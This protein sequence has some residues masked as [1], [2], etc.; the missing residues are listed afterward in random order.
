[1]PMDFES[2]P[3]ITVIALQIVFLL[4][5]L[6]SG[7]DEIIGASLALCEVKRNAL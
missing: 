2:G 3:S 6:F 1:M 4:N 7:Y 5:R